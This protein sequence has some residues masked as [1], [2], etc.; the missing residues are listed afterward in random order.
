MVSA[1]KL[2]TI[3]LQKPARK[4][5]RMTMTFGTT[6]IPEPVEVQSGSSNFAAE[7]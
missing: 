3:D 7:Q 4:L 1:L 6:I 2:N 5:T